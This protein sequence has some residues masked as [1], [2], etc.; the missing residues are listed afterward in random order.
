MDQRGVLTAGIDVISTSVRMS[1]CVISPVCLDVIV[2]R[3]F[4]ELVGDIKSLP[5]PGPLVGSL[6]SPNQIEKGG[7]GDGTIM[8]RF[9]LHG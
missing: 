2:R 7:N 5:V 8:K 3:Y 1:W 6:R 4:L 9:C